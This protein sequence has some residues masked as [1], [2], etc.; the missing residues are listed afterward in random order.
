MHMNTARKWVA[1]LSA[2]V[3]MGLALTGMTL[4]FKSPEERFIQYYESV[5]GKMSYTEMQ[6]PTY[7]HLNCTS[8]ADGY[9]IVDV[10]TDNVMTGMSG[11]QAGTVI[12]AAIT[13]YCPQFEHLLADG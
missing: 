2:A 6:L 11:D 5:H 4:T 12:A 10:Y 13:A 3:L 8:L 1:F 9:S 7:G